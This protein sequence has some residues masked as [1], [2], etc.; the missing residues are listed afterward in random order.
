MVLSSDP[1]KDDSI[2]NC[3]DNDHSNSIRIKN[4][5]NEAMLCSA[6]VYGH[7]FRHL[8]PDVDALEEAPLPLATPPS[9]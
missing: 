1:E 8:L 9:P 4:V 2:H 5:H 7:A 3:N 6:G